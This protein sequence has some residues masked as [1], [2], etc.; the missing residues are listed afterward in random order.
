VSERDSVAFDFFP[1][2]AKAKVDWGHDPVELPVVSG[3]AQ[4]LETNITE[5]ILG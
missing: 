5:I 4:D 3:T 1:G 2:A